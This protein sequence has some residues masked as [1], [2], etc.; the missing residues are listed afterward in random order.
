MIII[1]TAY[2]L[3]GV[4]LASVV[5]NNFDGGQA[6]SHS[7]DYVGCSF[8]RKGESGSFLG[9]A[10]VYAA[11]QNTNIFSMVAFGGGRSVGV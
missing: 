10:A 1:I 2:N 4:K 6:H 9:S 8:R 7:A 3:G 5:Q 11:D